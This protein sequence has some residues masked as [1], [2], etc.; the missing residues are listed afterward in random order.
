MESLPTR[1]IDQPRALPTDGRVLVHAA[2]V[3]DA[4]QP[5]VTF[6]QEKR[7]N[8]RVAEALAPRGGERILDVGCGTGLLTA[9]VARRMATGEV[10]GIDASR[11]MIDVA[12]RKRSS[13]ICRY[14]LAV[15]EEL[16]FDD[17]TFDAAVSALFFHHVPLDT[18]R[19]SAAE[20]VRVVRPGGRVV[21]ADI[22]TPWTLFGT[23]YAY[24]GWILLRQPEIKENIDGRVPATLREAGLTDV[25]AGAGVLGC[26]RIWSG[27]RRE[28]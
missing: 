15:A 18:K 1:P 12:T 14:E 28:D 22:D 10:I 17:G 25:E 19:R 23:C 27:R 9:E 2:R 4:V 21:V 5:W 3:Y 16:P 20:M 6:G 11:P 13:P 8:R 24:A 7:L 26:I